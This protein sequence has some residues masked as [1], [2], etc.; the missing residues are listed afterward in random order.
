VD[1]LSLIAL[2]G[3]LAQL[4]LE[5]DPT[6]LREAIKERRIFAGMP[7]R[8]L[9]RLERYS[10]DLTDC[11]TLHAQLE[12]ETGMDS[13]EN[14]RFFLEYLEQALYSHVPFFQECMRKLRLLRF[15]G[16]V[17]GLARRA[18]EFDS[19]TSFGAAFQDLLARRMEPEIASG[20][21]E[22]PRCP[23]YAVFDPENEPNLVV[24]EPLIEGLLF[25]G[26]TMAYG[27]WKRARKT[28]AFLAMALC[29]QAGVPFLG[30]RVKRSRCA[31]VQRDMPINLFVQYGRKIRAGLN[32]P[33]TPIPFIGD[34][35]NLADQGDQNLLL[36]RLDEFPEEKRIEVLFLDSSRSITRSKE[37]DSDE[38][39]LFV[40]GFLCNELRDK[41][42]L[43][44]VLVG[45]PGKHQDSVRGAGEW[46]A[47]ADTVLT[48]T[49]YPGDRSKPWRYTEIL[50]EGRQSAGE[51]AFSIKDDS[52][53]GGAC[54]LSEVDEES[55]AREQGKDP[56][57]TLKTRILKFVEENPDSL[58]T[59]IVE[60]V[61]G[62]NKDIRNE[63]VNLHA[64]GWIVK[65][66]TDK[67][68]T[69]YRISPDRPTVPT[70]PD[71]PDGQPDDRPSHRP[72]PLKG[73]WTGD[74][75]GPDSVENTNGDLDSI[76]FGDQP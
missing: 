33:P 62:R 72:V 67:P 30:R 53:F 60:R 37:N 64:L 34:P 32:L 50:G 47:A 73:R 69:R 27:K 29:I 35:I 65:S 59:Q 16:D 3:A 51:L 1:D 20:K 4:L 48:F 5:R 66:Q 42:G 56:T 44:V 26:Y 9:F 17:E 70:V 61:K 41:R 18:K 40:R 43:S 55:K 8:I 76:L 6:M 36:E 68:G 45:H 58:H 19:V 71:R 25:P 24:P 75:D 49:P 13:K 57:D 12:L 21:A 15:T 74:R 31:W 28:T 7:A 10:D 23:W 14:A 22:A 46:E 38:V 52:D 54:V 63:L 39:S 2:K 11:A